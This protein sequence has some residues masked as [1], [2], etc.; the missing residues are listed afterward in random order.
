MSSSIIAKK[1]LKK[2]ELYII[3]SSCKGKNALQ[4]SP[5]HSRMCEDAQNELRFI[6][7]HSSFLS[8]T[9]EGV[10]QSM[11][12]STSHSS[13]I[14]NTVCRIRKKKLRHTNHVFT[15][16][17]QLSKHC[18]LPLR[19][20]AELQTQDFK[21]CSLVEFSTNPSIF[22][23]TTKVIINPH[24]NNFLNTNFKTKTTTHF[25]TQ[26]Q[27]SKLTI[28]KSTTHLQLRNQHTSFIY[29]NPLHTNKPYSLGSRAI[30]IY[31]PWYPPSYLSPTQQ[32]HYIFLQNAHTTTT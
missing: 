29:Q 25:K 23:A 22:L 32:Q 12:V 11:M 4:H 3:L 9:Y 2:K 26:I 14:C 1:T 7:H 5:P 8:A 15:I 19:K 31:N 16:K 24:T 28:Y 30:F 21:S 17:S 27:T 6:A 10:P 13:E 18:N 20:R